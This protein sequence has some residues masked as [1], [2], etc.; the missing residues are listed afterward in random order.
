[1]AADLTRRRYLLTLL[2]FAAATLV[3]ALAAPLIGA[4]GVIDYGVAR[5]WIDTPT[6][7]QSNAAQILSMRVA[8]VLLGV[9]VGMALGTSGATFQALLRNPLA[10]PYV[11]GIAAAAAFGAAFA[12]VIPE[13]AFEL[14]AGRAVL[15]TGS[16][17]LAL[18]SI[19]I[20]V[21]I[22]AGF[23]GFGLRPRHLGARF[24]LDT[25]T[26]LLAGVT[27]TIFFGAGLQLLRFLAPPTKLKAIERL[28]LGDLAILSVRDVAPTLPML[29]PGMLLLLSQGRAL[30]QLA[31]GESFAAGRGIDVR[32]TQLVGVVG[33]TLV[34]AAV[35][36]VAGPIGFVG[37]IVPHAV[38]R[39]IG[40]DNRLVLPCSA[41]LGAAFLVACDAAARGV[42]YVTDSGGEFPV[43][44]ITAL[45]GAPAFLIILLRQRR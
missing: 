40:V 9:L 27:S 8:R 25:W 2:A 43:G 31:M 5:E 32:R 34:T 11:L 15:F 3:V 36:P 38:R 35:V 42:A 22:L 7:Q 29:L 41:L 1:M 39:L 28:L 33:A 24:G 16:Q 37:L 45:I 18:L 30:N 6:D 4:V 12:L 21:L 10:E 20:L 23:A 14:R 19:A 17:T 13:L 44:L 26:L